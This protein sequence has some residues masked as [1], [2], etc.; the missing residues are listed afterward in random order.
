M[1]AVD[2]YKE[3]QER[4][5]PCYWICR[6]RKSLKD[7]LREA[8]SAAQLRKAEALRAAEGGRA[9]RARVEEEAAAAKAEE[10]ASA[11]AALAEKG[12]EAAKEKWQAKEAHKRRRQLL[13][14]DEAVAQ[15]AIEMACASVSAQ[16]ALAAALLAAKQKSTATAAAP[17]GGGGWRADR[18]QVAAV[19]GAQLRGERAR[20]GAAG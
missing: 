1:G 15:N 14:E 3:Q 5:F 4:V 19:P 11:K 18:G 20:E 2:A 10:E 13:S 12:K 9:A 16:W 6:M 17:D 7:V 8:T